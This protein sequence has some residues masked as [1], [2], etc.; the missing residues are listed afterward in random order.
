VVDVPLGPSR[1]VVRVV[2]E[3][4]RLWALK[5]LPSWAAEREHA[6]LVEM[7]RRGVPAVR[8]V[9]LVSPDPEGDAGSHHR[10]R[11]RQRPVA[12]PADGPARQR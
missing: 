10:V 8:P 5:E 3:G 1:H 11:L 4:D 2:R 6:A 7:E 12:Q 9:G